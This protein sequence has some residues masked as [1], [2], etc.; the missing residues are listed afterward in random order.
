MEKCILIVSVTV[1][2]QNL[3][4]GEASEMGI[5]SHADV[6]AIVGERRVLKI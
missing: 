2:R 5:P 3:F 1:G 6:G 4:W